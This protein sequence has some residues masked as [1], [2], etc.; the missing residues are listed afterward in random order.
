MVLSVLY[1]LM[2]AFAIVGTRFLKPQ[3]TWG[4][5]LAVTRRNLIL[6]TLMF[7]SIPQII[8]AL[9]YLTKKF[10]A[11][12]TSVPILFFMSLVT[13]VLVG[14]VYYSNKFLPVS[15]KK[16]FFPQHQVF[17]W[18]TQNAGIDRFYGGGT[19]HID[20]NFPTYY[21]VYG[22]EG[23]DTLRLERYAQLLA[24][25]FSGSVPKTYLRS[26]AVVPN[27]ENG[28]RKRLFEILGV[29]YLLDKEDDPK[30]GADWHYERFQNDSV[31]GL[32]Q[33]GKF[34][35]YIRENTLPRAFLTTRYVVAKNDEEVINKIYDK[36]FSLNTVILEKEPLLK[37][38]GTEDEIIPQ[39]PVEY[40]SNKVRFLVNAGSNSL[41]YFS[42]SYDSDWKVYINK[43]KGELLRA[44]YALRAVA[45]PQG[46][47]DVEF[48][49]EP[50]S[51]YLGAYATVLCILV[52]STT[53]FIFNKKKIL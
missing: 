17:Y 47:H 44:N 51:F 29:K 39:E 11:A 45:I 28:Y 38:I 49:Y 9:N 48:K 18:L 21:K 37:I 25:S 40:V 26:D 20:F 27:E 42:D 33:N 13:V 53:L 35:I 41:L 2:W 31:K 3:D 46:S 24:S 23:Y 34:Q 10:K 16:F 36:S 14:G 6:P 19:A 22:I 1:V 7:L 30:T 32:W 4:I 52:I 8:L 12:K 5:N 43:K 50:I 15:P